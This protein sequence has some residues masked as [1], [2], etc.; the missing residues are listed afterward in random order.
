MKGSM[1]RTQMKTKDTPYQ[2]LLPREIGRS[3]YQGICI[4][5]HML[6][7]DETFLVISI[8]VAC[9]SSLLFTRL[10]EQCLEAVLDTSS[11]WHVLQ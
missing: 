4:S 3:S 10:F 1:S 5:G 7:Y 9:I 2:Q 6:E 8:V 11:P